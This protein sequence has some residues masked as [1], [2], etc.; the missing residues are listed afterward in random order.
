MWFFFFCF[1]CYSQRLPLLLFLFAIPFSHLLG[2]LSFLP[3]LWVGPSRFSSVLSLAPASLLLE[4]PKHTEEKGQQ[5]RPMEQRHSALPTLIHCAL[6]FLAALTPEAAS[7]LRAQPTSKM[8]NAC[9]FIP[10][11]GWVPGTTPPLSCISFC[12]CEACRYYYVSEGES[13]HQRGFLPCFCLLEEWFISFFRLPLAE[14]PFL[15]AVAGVFLSS[16]PILL[17]APRLLTTIESL[18]L[19]VQKAR[20]HFFLLTPSSKYAPQVRG[21]NRAINVYYC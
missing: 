2:V 21:I 5:G 11:L 6:G 1:N 19:P 17:H 20:F 8:A 14:S 9:F 10:K 18:P 15:T 4:R 7:S 12:H 3:P 16:N 13:W